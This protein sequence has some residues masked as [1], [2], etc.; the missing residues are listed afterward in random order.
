MSS[1]RHIFF[2]VCPPGLEPVLHGELRDLRLAKIERQ[3][4]GVYFEG[5]LEDAWRA[6]LELRTAVRV[7]L[8][9]ERFPAA[10]DTALYAA[11]ADVPWERWLA[12]EGTLRVDAHSRDSVL[13]HTRFIEQRVKDAICDRFRDRTGTRPSVDL[14]QP[15]LRVHAHLFRDRC[16]L[17]VDTS[18]DSLHKRGWRR[19]QGRAPLSETLA[20]GC[21]LLSGWD[22]R[23]PFLDPF[24]GSGT[25]LVEAAMIAADRPPG[26]FGRRFAFEGWPGHEATRWQRMRDE[27]RAASKLPRKLT[28]R[29]SDADA[30]HLD[31]A[32][33][34]LAAAGFEGA[35]ELEVADARDF[36]PRRGWNG[37]VVTNP[38]YGQRV[39][40][41]ADLRR[42]FTRFGH[43]LREH[44]AGYQVALL[45]GNK[46]LTAALGFQFDARTRLANGAL[47]CELLQVR[48]PEPAA[49]R[50]H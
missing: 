17:S 46:N 19:G 30:G 20:A 37:W 7:L 29:G 13:D 39:G 5:T 32:R 50:P 18:G 9:V 47:E 22:K 31:D 10:D 4:G 3:V 25:L 23:S 40:R 21:V 38:P 45:S 44:C 49:P 26:S 2:A 48:V 15:A 34:N 33:E 35:V 24:C 6:N 14:D 27:A 16:T 36:A 12:P 1:T 42:L 28:L 11:V 43:G 8:R 41:E